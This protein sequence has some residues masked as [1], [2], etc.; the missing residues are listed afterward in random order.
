MK[1]EYTC[2]SDHEYRTHSLEGTLSLGHAISELL[3]AN[4]VLVLIGNLGAGKTHLSKGI[5]E[6]L[7]SSDRVS[8]PT[9]NLLNMYDSGRL[10]V[11][12]FDLYRLEEA[13]Q[14]EDIDFVSALEAGGVSIIEWGDKFPD[15]LPDDRLIIDIQQDFESGER[16]FRL[17]AQG[18]RSKAL[19][20][21][22]Y[23]ATLKG[24]K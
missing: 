19:Q 12:H 23:A 6:G 24:N 4:D 5:V 8:S 7:G 17:T 9:F 22:L 13:E 11:Y 20:D 16:S 3:Q 1:Q 18:E 15:E 2:I 21:R 10:P 14:L